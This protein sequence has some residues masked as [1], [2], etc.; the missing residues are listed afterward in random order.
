[1]LVLGVSCAACRPAAPPDRPA[2]A[3]EKS[4]AE[5]TETPPVDSASVTSA[6]E[7]ASWD[8][9]QST[10]A[11]LN[12][13]G[14][15]ERVIIAADAVLGSRGQPLWE[16]G[17]RWAVYAESPAGERTLLYG[18]F[19]PNGFAQAAVVASDSEER[20]RILVQERTPGRIR[21]LEVE[22]DAPG[23]ARLASDVRYEIEEWLPGAA[24]FQE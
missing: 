1:M 16:D 14:Q 19:V 15:A 9:R 22:Y 3:A 12:G 18:A 2:G 13:D 11:D 23:M 10:A 4:P 6:D 5:E 20:L 24:R 21:A 17:H 8:Y 7:V